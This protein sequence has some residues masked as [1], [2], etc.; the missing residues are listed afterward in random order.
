MINTTFP[1]NLAITLIIQVVWA[2]LDEMSFLMINM[3]ISMVVPG[4]A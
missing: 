1:V 4:I 2:K 3:M